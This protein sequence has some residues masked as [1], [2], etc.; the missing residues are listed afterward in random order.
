M[1]DKRVITDAMLLQRLGNDRLWLPNSSYCLAKKKA[2]NDFKTE[3]EPEHAFE[4]L[5]STSAVQ[6][7]PCVS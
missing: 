4:I 7:E 6:R 1:W 5:T 2:G 3:P